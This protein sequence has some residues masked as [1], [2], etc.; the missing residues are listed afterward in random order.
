MCSR[1]LTDLLDQLAEMAVAIGVN[2]LWCET[3]SDRGAEHKL[4][5]V[6][7]QVGADVDA[8]GTVGLN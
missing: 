1:L 3:E 5:I 2:A 6:M 8:E 4:T 7:V